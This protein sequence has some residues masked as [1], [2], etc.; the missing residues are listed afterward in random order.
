MQLDSSKAQSEL[1]LNPSTE[2]ST[3]TQ[4]TQLDYRSNILSTRLLKMYY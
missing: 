2:V 4:N 1:Q 3:R